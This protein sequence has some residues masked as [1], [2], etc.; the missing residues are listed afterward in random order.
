MVIRIRDL[1]SGA[2]TA[3][4]GASVFPHIQAA[5][6]NQGPIVISFDGVQTATSSFVNSAFVPL[7][8]QRSFSG[9]KNRLRIVDSTRQI[10][11]MIKARLERESL[12]AA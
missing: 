4:E 1:V 6:D 10:N 7:L 2:N 11:E 12:V 3:H 8:R 5:F 9:I